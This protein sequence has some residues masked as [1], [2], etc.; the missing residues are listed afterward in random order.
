MAVMEPA[1]VGGGVPTAGLGLGWL[2]RRWWV[3]VVGVLLGLATAVGALLLIQPKYQAQTSVLVNS[4]DGTVDQGRTNSGINLDT[5]AQLVKSAVVATGAQKLLKSSDPLEQLISD[6]SVTVP[7]NTQV[8]VIGY[9]S[10]DPALAQRGSHSFAQAYLDQRKVKAQAALD[11][12]ISALNKQ[13]DALQEALTSLS[14]KVATLPSNSQGL[15]EAEAQIQI[16]QGQL[17]SLASRLSPLRAAQVSPGSIISD[18]EKPT[19]PISPN[20]ALVLA[21]GAAAGGLLGL[22][23]GL[24]LERFGRRLR[25][26]RDVRRLTGLPVV[27]EIRDDLPVGLNPNSAAS[28]SVMRVAI[29]AATA[30][31][32]SSW[33]MNVLLPPPILVIPMERTSGV[34]VAANLAEALAGSGTKTHLVALDVSL[35]PLPPQAYQ[36]GLLTA[37]E[38]STSVTKVEEM[39]AEQ[40]RAGALVVMVGPSLRASAA[41]QFAGGLSQSALLVVRAHHTRAD[42][43][44]EAVQAL[45]NMGLDHIAVVLMRGDGRAASSGPER[46]SSGRSH[47]K[48]PKRGA[49]GPAAAAPDQQEMPLPLAVDPD[50]PPALSLPPGRRQPVEGA[51]E[52]ELAGSDWTMLVNQQT[53][54]PRRRR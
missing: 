4:I 24:L 11:A 40:Q 36:S 51:P 21:S 2:A 42:E 9:L 54:G 27:A 31:R 17:T 35:P 19:S 20:R 30:H 5:E 3:P 45:E 41:V 44:Q 18:A 8:L 12:Q 32:T 23:L 34:L 1:E 6:V 43:V 10:T 46:S 52:P 26:E 22:L 48:G 53:D 39:L 15:K 33:R 25:S 38:M 16:T 14:G 47:G 49:R 29:L 13:Q 7:P 28:R 50:V 37:G